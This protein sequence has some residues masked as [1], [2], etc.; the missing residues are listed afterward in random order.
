MTRKSPFP[1]ANMPPARQGYKLGLGVVLLLLLL[2]WPGTANAQ[3]LRSPSYAQYNRQ[4]IN[5]AFAGARARWRVNAFYRNQFAN[6]TEGGTG[7]T[8]TAHGPLA[9]YRN[10]LGV[11]VTYDEIGIAQQFWGGVAYA[12]RIPIRIRQDKYAYLGLGLQ[13]GLMQF[14]IDPAQLQLTQ[15][16]DP[17]FLDSNLEAPVLEPTTDAGIFFHTQ[18]FFVGYS[19]WNL[20]DWLQPEPP[21][22]GLDYRSERHHFLMAGGYVPFSAYHYN[23]A[24]IPSGLLRYAEPGAPPTAEVSVLLEGLQRFWVGAGYRTQATYSLQ[25][26]FYP[27]KSL[28]IGYAYEAGWAD[29]LASFGPTHEVFLSWEFGKLLPQVAPPKYY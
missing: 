2:G 27:L 13:A 26:G 16:G 29:A 20:E 23:W 21:E 12:H 1:T 25:A 24:L 10:G 18:R 15:S 11:S 14:Q 28:R 8:A 5:P 17:T 7:L 9:G 4:A 6:L 3:A 19:V 22:D